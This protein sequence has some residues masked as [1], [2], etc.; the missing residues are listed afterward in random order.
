MRNFSAV[1]FYCYTMSL[2]YPYLLFIFQFDRQADGVL[3]PLQAKHVLTGI[4]LEC[5]AAILRK[6]ESH[7][8][9]DVYTDVL[10]DIYYVSFPCPLQVTIAGRV[11]LLTSMINDI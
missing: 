8:E 6:K 9:L 1:K 11:I 2:L 4:N 7:Y 5:L 3:G 10:R